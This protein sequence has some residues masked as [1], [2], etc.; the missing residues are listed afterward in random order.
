MLT[1]NLPSVVESI[2]AMRNGP[3]LF[4]GEPQVCHI[5]CSRHSVMARRSMTLTI[6]PDDQ[7]GKKQVNTQGP[8]TAIAKTK[9]GR[10]FRHNT[11]T[12][13]LVTQWCRSY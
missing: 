1:K 8:D 9:D 12:N 6:E 2:A 10:L 4:I 11:S 3:P 7:C 5:M 13:L